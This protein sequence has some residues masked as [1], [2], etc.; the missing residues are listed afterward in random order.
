MRFSRRQ[1]PSGLI[2]LFL[3]WTAAIGPLA[4]R[5]GHNG[6]TVD[7]ASQASRRVVSSWVPAAERAPE[8]ACPFCLIH[9]ARVIGTPAREAVA[10]PA[11]PPTGP[12][13]VEIGLRRSLLALP[14]R[15][16]APPA[17]S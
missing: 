11:S 2:A 16:R 5:Y 9:V 6:R 13:P 14:C 8:H 15:G 17:S 4:H 10:Q 7:L 12:P 3:L 1:T